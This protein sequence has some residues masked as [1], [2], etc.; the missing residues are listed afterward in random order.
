MKKAFLGLTALIGVGVMIA[1]GPVK[2]DPK[3][4]PYVTDQKVAGDLRTAG[5]DTMGNLMS[6][7]AQA[8]NKVHP[9]VR[10]QVESKGS[11][12]GPAALLESQGQFA[13]M[14]RPMSSKEIDQFVKKFGHAPTELRVGIDCLAVY[15]NKDCP[16]EE[17]SIPQLRRVFSVDGP[18]MRW[19]DLGVTHPQWADR[20]ISLHSRNAASG[21]YGFFKTVALGGADFKSTVKEAP[22]S[23]GVVGAVA[24][25]PLAMGYSGIGYSTPD[26]KALR[27]S[28]EDGE[29]GAEPSQEAANYGDYP[30]A[31]N[32]YVYVNYDRQAGLDTLRAEFI[33]LMFSREGQ[34]AVVKDGY[35]PVSAK[36]AAEDLAKVGLMLLP[37]KK[38]DVVDADGDS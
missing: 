38:K 18:D 20:P 25:D 34:E 37:A 27:V 3:L 19:S 1:S 15:V 6:L 29:P 21:T 17:I 14:S 10:I 5:S 22:G 32:L 24:T 8:F 7:Y 23:A 33:R 2:I 26:V 30:I 28:F 35:F 11:S 12:T 13:A 4:Q 36:I 31:R 16:L 9:G